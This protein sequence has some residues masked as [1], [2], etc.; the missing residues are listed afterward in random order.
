MKFAPILI[1]IFAMSITSCFAQSYTPKIEPCACNI[2]IEKGVI[3]RCGFLVVPE[4]RKHPNKAQIKIP[5]LFVRKEGMDSV[6]NI[7]LYS[8]GGPGYSTTM[9]ITQ[10]TANSGF[11]KYGGF[12]AF[13]Q[14]GTKKAIP[15]LF[16]PEIDEAIKRSYLENLSKD[17]LVLLAVKSARKKFIAQGIDL[18]AY[19]TIESAADIND[20]KIA[21]KIQSL[22]LVGISYSGGLMLTV[23]RNHPEGIKALILN[24]PLPGFVNY[25][26]HGLIN[27]DE[28]LNQVFSNVEADSL[29]EE[30]YKDLRNRFHDYFT[31]IS[32]QRFSLKYLPKGKTDSIN[33]G[34]GKTE[35]LD[36]IIGRIDNNRLK[37]VPFVMDEIIRGKHGSYVSELLDGIFSGDPDRALGMRYS[38]YCSEQIAYSDPKLIA[39]QDKILPWLSG[40][41]FNNVNEKICNCW[42]VK[43]EAP[44]AKNPVYS[45]I[46]ALISGGDAD[47]WCRP[48][49]NTLIKRY[50]PNAQLLLIHNR[51][52][53]SGFGPDGFDY[54]E[55]F[56]ADPYKKLISK[57]ANVKVY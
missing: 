2:K 26:E 9:G 50:M 10:I 8:T 42:Q 16:T 45:T 32:G 31:K 27:M 51:A 49:Y 46:P 28:A 47:P 48:F 55:T 54:L 6:K 24:S 30:R 41:A 43:K 23:A 39:Q 15:S 52:H 29:K 4:N 35:L 7:S 57:S 17:S 37:S 18:S 3:A 36:V 19:N 12:I 11:L 53:G 38:V 1:L 13:D 34:Y 21:L 56:M 14:R 5:F 33:I 40:Y 44:E 20:L 25:E 22:S